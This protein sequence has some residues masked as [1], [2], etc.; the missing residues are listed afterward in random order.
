MAT[1]TIT[2]GELVELRTRRDRLQAAAAAVAGVGHQVPAALADE[3]REIPGVV[4]VEIS[5]LLCGRPST[6]PAD[7]DSDATPH[8][9]ICSRCDLRCS[10]GL[11][12]QRFSEERS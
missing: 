2:V 1:E 12:A 7:V 9:A 5:C 10:A 4:D 8:A 6:Y 3:L 11:Q